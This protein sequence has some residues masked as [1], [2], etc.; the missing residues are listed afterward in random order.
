MVM[1]LALPPSI[2]NYPGVTLSR[3]LS[4]PTGGASPH[5]GDHEESPKAGKSG[6]THRSGMHCQAR[7]EDEQEPF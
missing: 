3:L 5:P 2:N 4:P 7:K 1:Q 6:G